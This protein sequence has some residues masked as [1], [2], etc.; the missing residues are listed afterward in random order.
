MV[1]YRHDGVEL[2]FHDLNA[3]GLEEKIFGRQ[4]IAH[5]PRAAVEALAAGAKARVAERTRK[6]REHTEAVRTTAVPAEAIAAYVR[7]RGDPDRAWEDEDE[8]AWS[9]I[10]Q[11]AEAIEE[12]GLAKAAA[13]A[14]FSR[15]LHQVARED[16]I[17]GEG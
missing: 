11:Y 7:Y 6:A 15:E 13:G 3:H 8:T 9:L 4:C 5:A 10:G 1:T 12:Q 2:P 16:V 14:K 17:P